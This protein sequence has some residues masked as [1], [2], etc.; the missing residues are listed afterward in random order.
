MT[1]SRSSDLFLLTRRGLVAER[2]GPSV[3][4]GL[5]PPPERQGVGRDIVG[6]DRAGAHIGALTD[7]YRRDERGVRADKGAVPDG[8]AVL[9]EPVVVAGD[10]AGADVRRRA[11]RRVAHVREVVH[12]RAGAELGVLDLDEV[13]DAHLLA[14]RGA[15]PKP[16]IG[17]D[18]R[19][20]GNARP[21]EVGEGV[22]YDAVLDDDAR[23]EIDVG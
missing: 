8:G 23:A 13:A 16:R 9:R 15:R 21:L 20:P 17:P 4:N 6:D 22:N 1:P 2:R 14:E 10:G 19:A 18:A 3:L 7:R 12:L 5:P 11:D